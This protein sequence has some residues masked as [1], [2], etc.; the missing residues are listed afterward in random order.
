MRTNALQNLSD[1]V[2]MSALATMSA[3]TTLVAFLCIARI[4]G[5]CPLQ[6]KKATDVSLIQESNVNAL[7]VLTLG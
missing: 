2:N 1:V 5:V 6:K 4:I 7:G 3:S